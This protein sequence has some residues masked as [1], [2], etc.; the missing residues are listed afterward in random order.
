MANP[1]YNTQTT[2]PRQKLASGGRAKAMGG[3]HLWYKGYTNI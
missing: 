2:N 1:R 3:E